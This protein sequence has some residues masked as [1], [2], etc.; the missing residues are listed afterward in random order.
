MYYVSIEEY[1]ATMPDEEYFD[2]MMD[3]FADEMG[4]LKPNKITKSV[5]SQLFFSPALI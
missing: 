2:I 5:N 3:A 1:I 4:D